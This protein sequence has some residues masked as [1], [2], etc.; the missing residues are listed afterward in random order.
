MCIYM[1]IATVFVLTCAFDVRASKALCF[2][3]VKARPCILP[4]VFGHSEAQIAIEVIKNGAL[5]AARY[6]FF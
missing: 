3:I 2:T 5:F 4:C 6:V 1:Y